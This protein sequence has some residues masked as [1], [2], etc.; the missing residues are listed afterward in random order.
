MLRL[1][2]GADRG[3]FVQALEGMLNLA[4]ADC[5]VPRQ[6]SVDWKANAITAGP[7]AGKTY[8]ER[9]KGKS[10]SPAL[11]AR[12]EEALL[13]IHRAGYVLDRVDGNSIL[14]DDD[15]RSVVAVGL[16]DLLPLSGLSQ[17]MSVYLRDLDRDAFNRL[18]GTKLLTA[19]YL[20]RRDSAPVT[21]DDADYDDAG[22]DCAYASIVV[23]DDVHWGS[24]WN[25]DVG[26][27]RWDYILNDNLPIPQGGT[28]LDLGSNVGLNP[29]QM[30]RHG[31]ES[32][33][34]IEHD[35][36][37]A[38]NSLVLKAA[39][40]WL[41]NRSYDFRCIQASFADL[42][43][44]GLG[45]FDVV[46]ALCAL[47]YLSEQEMRDIVK[48]IRTIT[49]VLVLQ[50]NTDRLIDRSSEE[51]YRKASIEFAI[52]VLEQARFAKIEV[53]APSGYSRPLVIGSA[54]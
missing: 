44:L 31:A 21:I 34:G 42:P 43:T 30:L 7:V 37:K 8:S 29:L 11:A 26:T 6:V 2:F 1:E 22:G 49:D 3:R 25:T 46:T 15:G 40:E 32:A 27:A 14:I 20:R 13:S 10:A 4:E 38:R 47:Y 52:E 36:N 48:Y 9:L 19:D 39:F 17:D 54:P 53:I 24:I 23:R 18:F 16:D 35:E 12:I 50:C 51:T 33:V 5:A 41:D 45:R 28:V